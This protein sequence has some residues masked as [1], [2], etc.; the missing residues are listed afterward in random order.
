MRLLLT[1]LILITINQ[2]SIAQDNAWKSKLNQTL[3]D[4]KTCMS[5][6]SKTVCDGY[7]SKAIK[8]V[9]NVND[10]YNSA[11][12]NEMSPYEIQQFVSKSSEWTKLGPAYQ[13]AV[14]TK[15]QELSNSGKA[16]IVILE[17]DT[18][19]NVHVSVVL[20]GAL[21]SSGSWAMRVPSVAAFFTHN[22]GNSFVDKSISYAYTKSMMLQLQVYSK[23]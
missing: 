1:I 23:N 16:V 10:F 14:L 13:V 20:P 9:Y 3:T 4:F 11:T 15:A 5:T 8:Q 2:I 18:P 22:P 12:Q 6:E 19:A 21:Q 17:D 7:T